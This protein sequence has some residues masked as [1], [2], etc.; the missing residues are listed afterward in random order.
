MKK[1]R[2]EKPY[3]PRSQL[4]PEVLEHKRALHRKRYHAVVAVKPGYLEK[5]REDERLRYQNL[6]PEARKEADKQSYLRKQRRFKEATG[7]KKR[8]MVEK[9][10]AKERRRQLRKR[11]DSAKPIDGAALLTAAMEHIPKSLPREVRDE[12][13]GDMMLAIFEGKITARDIDKSAPAFVKKYWRAFG[14]AGSL[15]LDVR[16]GDGGT[17][18]LDLLADETEPYNEDED[19]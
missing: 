16:V 18:Y 12:V 1:P 11:A 6:S 14:Y 7:E 13:A 3:I 5:K 9:L 4:S 2:K 8:M 15:S 19:A 10:R 17:T